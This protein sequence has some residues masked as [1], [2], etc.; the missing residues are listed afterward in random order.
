MVIT[1]NFCT[2]LILSFF[3]RL[4]FVWRPHRHL[5]CHTV[6][7]VYRPFSNAVPSSSVHTPSLSL[8]SSSCYQSQSV[9]SMIIFLLLYEY[10][11]K[12]VYILMMAMMG[13]ILPMIPMMKIVRLVR[14]SCSGRSSSGGCCCCGCVVLL[15]LLVLLL[16]FIICRL[17]CG[18]A[19]TSAFHIAIILSGK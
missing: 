5:W 9:R 10:G 11:S 12:W 16:V 15:L 7:A 3:W 4:L 17:R 8:L 1:L 19:E 13:I 2:S 14:R 18:L 6:S